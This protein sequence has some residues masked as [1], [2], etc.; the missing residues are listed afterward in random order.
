MR[1]ACKLVL[2]AFL[3]LCIRTNVSA[4]APFSIGTRAHYGFIIPHSETIASL[5]NSKPRGFEISAQWLVNDVKRVQRSGVISKRGVLLLYMNYNNP[6]VLGWSLSVAPYVQPLIRPDKRL[7]G[8]F[9]MGGGLAFIN[10]VYDEETNP[11]NFFFSTKISFLLMTNAYLHFKVNPQ[12]TASLAFNYNHI[13]NGGI[14]TPNKGMNFPS[15]NA[16][17]SYALKPI[18]IKRIPRNT[19]WKSKPRNYASVHLASTLKTASP[20]FGVTEHQLKSIHGISFT[21]GRRIGHLSGLALGT[22]WIWDGW[23]RELLDRENDSASALRGSILF[24]HDLLIHKVRFSTYF[25]VYLFNPTRFHHFTENDAIY[26]RYSLFYTFG[27]RL[28]VGT[29]LKAHRQV[30]EVFDL[31]VGVLF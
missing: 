28:Q 25:G 15:Y 14:K 22:E 26:Q 12:W 2:S 27:K 13:S 5:A 4:Q 29:T 23:T 1:I 18:E 30:A 20:S 16:G 9:Q 6:D 24:G 31:R 17:F 21:A 7:Y 3:L 11:D 8:S 19:E 10:K